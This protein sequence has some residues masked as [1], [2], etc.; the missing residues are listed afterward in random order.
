MRLEPAHE[1]AFTT[2]KKNAVDEPELMH[3]Y[4][5][6]ANWLRERGKTC[7]LGSREVYFADWDKAVPDEPAFDIAFPY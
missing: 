1:E 2:M 6:A 3:G 4:D 5:A 7:T